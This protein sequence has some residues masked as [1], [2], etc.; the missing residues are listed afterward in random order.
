MEPRKEP[1]LSYRVLRTF[2]PAFR[3]LFPN[4]VIPADELGRAMVDVAVGR[5]GAPGGQILENRNIRAMVR[6]PSPQTGGP[7]LG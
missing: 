6:S 7:G 3:V 1:N 2:Y 4:Q 5:T